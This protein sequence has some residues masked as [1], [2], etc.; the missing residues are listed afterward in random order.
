MSDH[1]DWVASKVLA[2]Y[3]L[4]GRRELPWHRRRTPYRVWVSEVMLQQTQVQ[5]VVPF[6]QR[7]MARFP[8]VAAL[9]RADEGEVLSLW[10]GLGYYRRA[11]NLYQTA[12]IVHETYQGK[13]P[14]SLEELMALPGIGRSTAGA[15]LAQAYEL[16]GVILDANVRRVIARFHAKSLQDN[17]GNA[18]LWSLAS[19]HTPTKRAGDYAQAMMDL[20]SRVCRSG[21]PLCT[22]CPLVPRCEGPPLGLERVHSPSKKSAPKRLKL[23]RAFLIASQDGK[24]L[25]EK[26]P[27]GGPWAGLWTPPERDI[28]CEW[29]DLAPA[30]NLGSFANAEWH[31]EQEMEHRLSHIRYVVVPVRVDL[32]VSSAETDLTADYRWHEGGPPRSFGMSALALK[33]LALG[34][35]KQ[36][37]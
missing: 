28:R 2:W 10:T 13:L 14:K 26:R 22:S 16:Q 6:F 3:D 4:H 19:S 5:T 23:V 17:L 9:A 25:L 35:S 1:T 15:I 12:K 36:V 33:L 7:F 27:D 11:R 29:E 30:L 21:T 20:G 31:Q 32:E 34:K 8:S 37:A 24:L 18:Q